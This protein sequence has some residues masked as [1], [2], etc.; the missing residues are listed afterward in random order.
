MKNKKQRAHRFGIFAE[1]L[2]AAFLF[3]KGYQ[4]IKM[5]YRNPKGE[6]DILARKGDTIIAVEVKARKCLSD[7]AD[8]VSPHKQRRI[9]QSITWLMLSPS[10]ITGLKG[11]QTPNIRFDVVWVVP[12]RLPKHIPDAWRIS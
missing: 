10:K 3:F 11:N 12:Y 4:I 7:C 1:Y 2:T 6:I 8:A 9:Q 5:R